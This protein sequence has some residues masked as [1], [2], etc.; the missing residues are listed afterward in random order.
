VTPAKFQTQF[1]LIGAERASGCEPSSAA[2]EMQR[3][4]SNSSQMCSTETE[5]LA[6]G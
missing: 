6:D 3:G 2:A 1:V 4:A 5:L